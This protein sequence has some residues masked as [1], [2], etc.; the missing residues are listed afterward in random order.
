MK[1]PAPLDV[2]VHMNEV[3]ALM[4]KDDPAYAAAVQA[5]RDYV[6]AIRRACRP[7]GSSE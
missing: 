7:G 4:D 2:L 3:I 1:I 6:E 5:R